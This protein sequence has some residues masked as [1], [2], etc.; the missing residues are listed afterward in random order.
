[1]NGSETR[2]FIGEAVKQ[3]K[4]NELALIPSSPEEIPQDDLSASSY[5]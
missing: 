2:E 5:Y 3:Q 1:M 4:M